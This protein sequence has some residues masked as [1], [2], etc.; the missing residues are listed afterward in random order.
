MENPPLLVNSPIGLDT[1][2]TTLLND[3]KT[4]AYIGDAVYE[5]LVRQWVAHQWPGSPDVIHTET[6]QRVCAE[7]QASMLH[8]LQEQPGLLTDD[9]T[10]FV[11]RARNLPIPK[12]RRSQHQEYRAATAL[13]ALI[14]RW[15]IASPEK[16]AHIPALLA[17]ELPATGS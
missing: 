1:T 17:A 16:L 7:A 14:G 13:E 8:Q 2:N 11:K 12:Q 4:A 5:L 3:A 15:F 10:A 6:T 9:D